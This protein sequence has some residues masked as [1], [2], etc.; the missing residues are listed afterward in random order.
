[1]RA[2]SAAF[3][4]VAMATAGGAVFAAPAAAQGIMFERTVRAAVN[5]G[6]VFR[7]VQLGEET[8]KLAGELRFNGLHG[9]VLLLQPFE[10]DDFSNETRLYGGWSPH[11][12]DMGSKL[13][14]EFG[15]TWYATPD[16][17]PGFSDESR[18]EPYAKLFIDAPLMPSIAGFYDI[19]REA[20]TVEG[21]LTQWVELGG[22]NGLELALD[23]GLV[24]PDEAD[25]HAYALGSVE[26]VRNFLNG[27]EGY[28]GLKGSVSSEDLYFDSLAPT[29]PIYDRRAKAWLGAGFSASF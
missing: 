27:V 17:A 24:S 3:C 16:A 12:E 10:T 18:F 21:R 28:V 25:E 2:S 6:Y 11:L 19:E 22:L 7:G 23:G 15:F 26:F 9:G 4:A 13:D 20:Y 8:F 14:L 5:T 1:M 29:G